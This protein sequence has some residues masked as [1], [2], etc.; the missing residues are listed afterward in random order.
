MP[1]DFLIDRPAAVLWDWL[2][3]RIGIA[4]SSDFVGLGRVKDGE[5]IGVVGY[6][7][8][9]GT[10]CHMHM[11]GDHPRW[12]TRE[13]I[14]AAFSYPFETLGL[15]MVFGVVPSG[16][17]RALRIDA[18]LGFRELLYIPGAHPDGGIHILQ[19]KREE[20]RWLRKRDGKE[21]N[22]EAA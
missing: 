17:I 20:C 22:P 16:N 4:Y 18:K 3:K 11:A 6:N 9:T 12:I 10:S 19:M 8:F 14:H 1:G 7:N 5:L 15:T 21:I 13:F 2:S